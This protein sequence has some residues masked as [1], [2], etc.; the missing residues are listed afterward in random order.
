MQN[1][2]VM[3]YH[4]VIYLKNPREE[5]K[6]LVRCYLGVFLHVLGVEERMVDPEHNPVK[7]GAV[8]WLGHGIPHGH[9]LK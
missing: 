8:Q 5:P 9:S 4:S 1:A 3:F 7:Q 2:W 6:E